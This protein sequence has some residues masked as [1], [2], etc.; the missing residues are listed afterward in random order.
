LP[1][2]AVECG[3]GD[4]RWLALRALRRGQVV[5]VA[6]A[7][8]E[9]DMP[10]TLRGTYRQRL[11]WSRSWWWMFPYVFK[12]LGARQVLSPLYGVTQLLVTPIL[13][14]YIINAALASSGAR[15]Q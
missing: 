14:A 5:A 11:R 6:E 9:T 12:Y 13:V 8:V 10:S 7:G 4:D 2:Y 3:T 1:A 15:Y